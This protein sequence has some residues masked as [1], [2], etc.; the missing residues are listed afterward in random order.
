MGLN[1]TLLFKTHSLSFIP[2]TTRNKFIEETLTGNMLSFLEENIDF[3][4]R[5]YCYYAN[6]SF[7]P[8]RTSVDRK[9][10]IFKLSRLFMNNPFF[11]KHQKGKL[12]E[13]KQRNKAFESM[14]AYRSI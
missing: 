7:V 8:V 4:Y 11:T 10:K 5:L 6:D 1:T 13:F 14:L 12:S 2:D 3:F 9:C